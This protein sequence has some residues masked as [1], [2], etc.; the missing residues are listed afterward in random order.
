MKL[1]LYRLWLNLWHA[2][3]RFETRDTMD[4]WGSKLE[5]EY[6]VFNRRGKPIGYWAYGSY[7]PNGFYQGE[8]KT[9]EL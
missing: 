9:G 7:D 6:E 2:P 1:F 4:A 8:G 3:V 5:T